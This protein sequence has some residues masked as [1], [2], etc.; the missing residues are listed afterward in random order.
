MKRKIL[1]LGIIVL[2]LN[3]FTF[4]SLADTDDIPANGNSAAS[5]AAEEQK[6]EEKKEIKE[7]SVPQKQEA[8]QKQDIKQDDVAN[9]SSPSEGGENA[10]VTLS[11]GNS[12]KLEKT[13]ANLNDSNDSD[14]NDINDTNEPNDANPAKEYTINITYRVVEYTGTDS[15]ASHYNRNNV[16]RTE[17]RTITTTS[18]TFTVPLEDDWGIIEV[19][20]PTGVSLNRGNINNNKYNNDGSI[21]GYISDEFT[22]DTINLYLRVGENWTS[23]VHYQE[24]Y[25]NREDGTYTVSDDDAL[26]TAAAR[27]DEDISNAVNYSGMEKEPLEVVGVGPLAPKGWHYNGRMTIY[28]NAAGVYHRLN[29]LS[30][31]NL[32][33]NED[34]TLSGIITKLSGNEFIW[35]YYLFDEDEYKVIYNSNNGSGQ[36][37]GD[38]NS[39]YSG[40][41]ANVGANPFNYS[42]YKFTGWNTAA[43]GSGAAYNPDD[44][45]AIDESN[46]ILYAQ[47]EKIEEPVDPVDPVDPEEPTI[48]NKTSNKTTTKTVKAETATS[49]KTADTTDLERWMSIL[50]LSLTGIVYAIVR[51]IITRYHN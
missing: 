43:D 11:D 26:N 51:R 32:S 4:T 8:E 18:K 21:D 29:D 17:T 27:S 19:Q 45:V 37:A 3:M 15:G 48:E 25:K 46:I 42:G 23:R 16:I 12:E 34:G 28:Y 6:S 31:F 44:S 9:A 40:D 49:P 24:A 33:I 1:V 14:T 36:F 47:W 41:N 38:P 50:I 35:I 5:S 39:Y 10:S 7:D 30:D 13:P 20:T 22:G 2:I